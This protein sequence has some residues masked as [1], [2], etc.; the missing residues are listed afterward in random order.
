MREQTTEEIRIP[1]Q[2]VERISNKR[3]IIVRNGW[4]PA[5]TLILGVILCLVSANIFPG[6]SL[7]F[8]AVIMP[9]FFLSAITQLS[10]SFVKELVEAQKSLL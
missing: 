4:A 5:K 3:H 2:S 1:L 6:S 9:V 7:A 8:I 10:L